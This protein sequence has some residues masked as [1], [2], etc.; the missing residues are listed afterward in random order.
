MVALIPP[1]PIQAQAFISPSPPWLASERKGGGQ[2]GV[3]G[4]VAEAF[5]IGLHGILFV[6]AKDLW[7]LGGC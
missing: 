5:S 7:V 1:P 4:N 3:R 2:R 6:F